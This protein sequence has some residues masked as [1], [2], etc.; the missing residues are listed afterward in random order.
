MSL[1][2]KAAGLALRSISSKENYRPPDNEICFKRSIISSIEFFA[3]FQNSVD[4]KGKTVLDVGCGRGATCFY[5][6][7]NGA[8]KVVGIDINENALAFARSQLQ[9]HPKLR[10]I[11]A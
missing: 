4:F 7:L 2:Q 11:L 3:R 5:M 1:F 9:K 8:S 6:A 10:D